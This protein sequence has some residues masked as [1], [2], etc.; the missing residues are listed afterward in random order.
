[1][2]V[3]R[4]GYGAIAQLG[5]RLP[6]TQEVGGSIPPGSTTFLQVSTN[7]DCYAISVPWCS[8]HLLFNNVDEVKLLIWI[9]AVLLYGMVLVDRSGFKT[10]SACKSDATGKRPV[11]SWCSPWLE[12]VALKE[13]FSGYMV[14]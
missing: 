13:T 8:K 12:V 7:S 14:K 10:A 2:P 9:S 3:N 1:M 4:L 11:G 5:E 6:C